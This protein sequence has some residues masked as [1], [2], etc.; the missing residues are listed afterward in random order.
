MP[1][2]N[3]QHLELVVLN[4]TQHAVVIDTIAPELAEVALEAL[5]ELTGVVTTGDAGIEKG[6]DPP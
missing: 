4:P 2:A 5:S 1:K 6:K 3:D